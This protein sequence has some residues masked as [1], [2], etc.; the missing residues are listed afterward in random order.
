MKKFTDYY[1]NYSNVLKHAIVGFE[2]EFY[3]EKPYYKLLELFNRELKPIKV[4]GF[5]KYHSSFTPDA[6]NFKIEPDLSGGIRLVE[7]ITGPMQYPD[8]KIIMLKIIHN[9]FFIFIINFFIYIIP[10]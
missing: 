3:T 9:F 6:M 1:I 2:F 4:H 5:R 8:C 7:L 10:C